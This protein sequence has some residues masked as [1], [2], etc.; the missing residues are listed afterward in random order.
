[1]GRGGTRGGNRPQQ[2][3]PHGYAG[4]TNI[5][6]AS[7]PI[8]QEQKRMLLQQEKYLTQHSGHAHN[9]GGGGRVATPSASHITDRPS[10]YRNMSSPQ[11]TPSGFTPDIKGIDTPKSNQYIDPKRNWS[12]LRRKRFEKISK[13]KKPKGDLPFE[14]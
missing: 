13:G 3:Q 5:G 11:D 10:R 2:Q 9:G 4:D 14:V 6:T 1:M 12:Y 8:P 7:L